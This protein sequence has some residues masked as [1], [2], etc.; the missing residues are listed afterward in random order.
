VKG[1]EKKEQQSAGKGRAIIF[2]GRGR[3]VT[4]STQEAEA[5]G[6]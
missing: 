5:K 4:R 2:L 3:E 1:E 6:E